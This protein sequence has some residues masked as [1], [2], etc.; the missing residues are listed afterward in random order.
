MR[1]L[2]LLILSLMICSSVLF[3]QKVIVGEYVDEVYESGHPYS[4]VLVEQG[5]TT[6][7]QSESISFPD[8]T[9]IA[10][11]FAAFDLAEG[12]FVV[13]RSPDYKQN[14]VL[15]DQGRGGRGTS[16]RGFFATHINGDT[17]IVELY[18]N[19]THEGYGFV[20]DFFGRGYSDAEIRH[21]WDIG[22]GEEMNL[23]DPVGQGRSLCTTD[24]TQEVKCYQA[25]EP[26]AYDKARAVCRL[27]LNGSAHCTGWLVGSEGHVLTNE[28][29]IGSQSQLDDIDFD[30]M[31]EGPD[32]ATNCASALACPG[33]VEASGGTLIK[34]DATYDF[35]LVMPD[36]TVGG[37]TDLPGT[38]GY[39][40]LRESGAVVGERMYIVQ[41]PA[42]WGKRIAMESTY[43]TD[44]SDGYAHVYS[45]TEPACSGG[46]G[47]S[48][49]GYFADTQG[50]SSG[51]P[52]FGY[53]D[54][55]I[56]AL[57]HCRGSAS[58]TSGNVSTDDPNRGVPIQD[59]ITALG[60]DLP[61]GATCDPP[62][63]PTG[64]SV[65]TNGDNQL[66]VSWNA[67]AGADT[68]ILYRSQSPC[69][70]AT[71]VLVQSGIAGTSY[72]DT[73]VSGSITYSYKV[74]AY[75]QSTSCEGPFSDCSEATATGVCTLRPVFAGLSTATNL[76]ASSCGISLDWAAGTAQCGSSLVYNV[77]R[78]TTSGFVPGPSNLI[79]SCISELTYLDED[80]QNNTLYY[81]V[82]RAED[83][84]G[85]GAGNCNSGNEDTNTVEKSA[86]ASGPNAVMFTDDVE[87]G[88]ANFTPVTGPASTGTSTQWQIVDGTNGSNNHYHSPIHSWFCSDQPV[89]KDE[90]LQT[91][92]PIAVPAQLGVI[93]RW[94]HEVEMEDGW[95]GCVLEYSIDGT[96]WFDILAGDGA[97]IPDNSNRFLMNGYNM[98]LKGNTNP[99]NAR[100][101][102]SGDLGGY[103]EVQVD[104]SDFSATSVSFRWRVG[105]DSSANDEGWWIDDIEVLYP[106]DCASAEPAL[107]IGSYT[108]V[109]GDNFHIPVNQLAQ[110]S[111]DFTNYAFDLTYDSSKIGYRGTYTSLCPSVTVAETAPGILHITVNCPAKSPD[112][113]FLTVDFE[114]IAMTGRTDLLGTNLTGTLSGKM[115]TAGEVILPAHVDPCNMP[116]NIYYSRWRGILVEADLDLDS[117]GMLSVM[118]M[119]QQM[120]CA[121]P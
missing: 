109:Y 105:T 50:G 29:C 49:V 8:A 28:H 2:K 86:F 27:L 13:V 57:H 89:I 61:N 15:K 106:T 16:A 35:A 73:D 38:Y 6:L 71:F 23:P 113:D 95:D 114:V 43:S 33:T 108:G 10:L 66:D 4:K 44:S 20:I 107:S 112:P 40:Q 72:A 75:I 3:A 84:T 88:G 85:N 18:S 111:A 24:D 121:V 92:N 115:A 7:I 117:D 31:A 12:D 60:A 45:I 77:Y 63:A 120:L 67:V 62:D 5:E 26:A 82:V 54:N 14:Y 55:R 78:D 91:T 25:S 93:L 37:G 53:S 39:M 94:F 98:A 110:S 96:N 83:D 81:Y 34:V 46:T 79:A 21:Y 118:D 9:Y 47:D 68:Y 101:G 80:V 104:L 65:V 22:L 1:R 41:H 48:D 76:F 52:V 102:W 59:V 42:G 58:C 103:H 90:Y 64:V 32:C 97:S 74:K 70:G 19:N 17:A 56:I 99:L 51:S 30:F 119:L 36:T 100:Q 87:S 69:V 116:G 11:H